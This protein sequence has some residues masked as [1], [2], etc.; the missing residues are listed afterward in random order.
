MEEV[1]AKWEKQVYWHKIIL[2]YHSTS[3]QDA[4]FPREVGRKYCNIHIKEISGSEVAVGLICLMMSFFSCYDVCH[5]WGMCQFP[6]NTSP[7]TH[8]YQY[9]HVPVLFAEENILLD[10][11]NKNSPR[12]ISGGA[13]AVA[14]AVR[15]SAWF[16]D[17][18]FCF[19]NAKCITFQ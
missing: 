7:L 18:F 4:I 5:C 11:V 1:S 10:S 9:G 15:F 19:W 17:N 3:F 6:S 13:F 8:T 16:A 14:N 12:W 2:R